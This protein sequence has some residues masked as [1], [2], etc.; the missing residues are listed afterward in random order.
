MVSLMAVM[1]CFILWLIHVLLHKC[2]YDAQCGNHYCHIR[3]LINGIKWLKK[4][5][6]RKSEVSFERISVFNVIK[7]LEHR[8]HCL[9]CSDIIDIICYHGCCCCVVVLHPW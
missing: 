7:K 3:V 4:N 5:Y 8:S 6:L 2:S 1:L 9:L